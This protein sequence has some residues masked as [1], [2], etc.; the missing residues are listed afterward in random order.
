MLWK[1]EW[2]RQRGCGLIRWKGKSLV[3]G[4]L[5]DSKGSIHLGMYGIS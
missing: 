3:F 2:V 5:S 4:L 1:M